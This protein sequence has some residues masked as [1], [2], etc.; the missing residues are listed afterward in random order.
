MIL[1]ESAH[2]KDEVTLTTVCGK[3]GVRRHTHT[4][5]MKKARDV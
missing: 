4:R 1:A 3:G 2:V 5:G